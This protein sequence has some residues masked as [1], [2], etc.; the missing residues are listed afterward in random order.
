M[1]VLFAMGSRQSPTFAAFEGGLRALGY[2]D[3]QTVAIEFRNAEGR[4]DRLPELVGELLA[5][6]V[7]VIVTAAEGALA[8]RAASTTTP[9]VLFLSADPV[10]A[11]LVHS[12]ARPGG[13]VTGLTMLSPGAATRRMALV[14]D[15]VP[16]AKTVVALWHPGPLLEAALAESTAAASALGMTLQPVPI[17]AAADVEPAFAE[18]DRIRPEAVLVLGDP[19]T[20]GQRAPIVASATR[21]RL[22]V[23]SDRREFADAGAV[24]TYGANIPDLFR[25]AAGHT[26]KVLKGAKPSE[27]PVE[28][29]VKFDLGVNLKAATAL[30]V[31]VPPALLSTADHVIR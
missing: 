11:G 1:G 17:R 10:A 31:A 8:A 3:G 13:N 19:V 5:A 24:V 15:T 6:R 14:R 20:V 12:L 21:R 18:I 26:D 25:R 16:A 30:G 9:I 23:F 22:P 7:D 27:L 29:P 2:V 4:L 28:T